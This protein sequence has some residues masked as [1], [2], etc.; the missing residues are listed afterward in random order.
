MDVSTINWGSVA[1][2]VSGI[3][4]LSAAIV[5]LY[6]AK[7]SQRVRLR[8]YCGYTVR[9]GGGMLKQNLV[10]IDITNIGSRGT[11][12]NNIGI[13]IGLFRRRYGIIPVDRDNYSDKIPMLLN[14]GDQG[15]WCI[16][17]DE[18]FSWINGLCK[19]FIKSPLDI[20]T[21]QIQVHTTNGGTQ[22]IRPNKNLRKMFFESLN[23]KTE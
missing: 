10:S 20:A 13:R 18:K 9:L 15:H 17:L 5:A 16:P 23:K 4:S 21:M 19:D 1:D 2:W 11:V 22:N 3:G 6:I 14:D 8:G 7:I 12:I